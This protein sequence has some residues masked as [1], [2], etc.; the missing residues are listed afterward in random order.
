MDLIEKK[1]YYATLDW[2]REGFDGG[3]KREHCMRDLLLVLTPNCS[4]YLGAHAN[5]ERAFAEFAEM[6]V[7]GPAEARRRNR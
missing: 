4:P 5:V 3:N 7:Y 6:M 2:L 1:D